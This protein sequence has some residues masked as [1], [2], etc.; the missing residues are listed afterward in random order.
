MEKICDLQCRDFVFV[1]II[2]Y[3]EFEEFFNDSKVVKQFL[4]MIE[5]YYLDFEG[6]LCYIW[7]LEGKWLFIFKLQFVVFVLLCYEI[8]VNVYDFL[9]GGYLGVNKIYVKFCECYFWFKMYMD[10]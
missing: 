8:F 7:V 4:Y 3:L 6:I 5:Q 2:E 10:V 1:D 9:I